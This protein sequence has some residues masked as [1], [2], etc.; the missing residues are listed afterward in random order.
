M[1]IGLFVKP[2]AHFNRGVLQEVLK[3]FEA[4]PFE[5]VFDPN[6]AKILKKKKGDFARAEVIFSL[7]GDGTVLKAARLAYQYNKPLIGVNLGNLGFLTEVSL[8]ELETFLKKFDPKKMQKDERTLLQVKLGKFQREVL[9]EVAIGRGLKP[10]FV[11]LEAKIDGK[12]LS[13][14]RADGLIIATPT[15]STAYSLAAGGPIL[16]P[17]SEVIVFNPVAPHKL[18][19]RPLILSDFE[20]ISIKANETLTVF[21]DGEKGPTLKKEDQLQ[22]SVLAR[23]V[24]FLRRENWNFFDVL[25]NKLEF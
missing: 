5:L 4:S 8:A 20:K 18:S 14:I 23:K 9:N 3:F 6:L 10:K 16:T 2:R 1:K 21:C 11:A 12:K 25:A 19:N 7:G 24:T 13:Q 15:G 22:I 17:N